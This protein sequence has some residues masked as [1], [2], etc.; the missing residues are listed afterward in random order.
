MYKRQELRGGANA[1]QRAT[2]LGVT[3]GEYTEVD[4]RFGDSQGVQFFID[5]E[6]N[7]VWDDVRE[8]W[9]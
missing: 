7:N 6:K 2:Y 1:G 5:D 9:I 3:T 4:N 8:D